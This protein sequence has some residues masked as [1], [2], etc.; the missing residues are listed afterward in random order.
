MDQLAEDR[1]AG[2]ATDRGAHGEEQRDSQGARLQWKDL[3]DGETGR[4][5]PAD[6]M[7][8]ASD[9]S[10]TNV[11]VVSRSVYTSTPR[12]ATTTAAPEYVPV[13]I[14]RRPT[15]SRSNVTA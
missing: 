4:A 15:V 14:G 7:K 8:N 5:R 9:T 12:S 2:D 3:T 11:P 1:G 6:A 13:I 10:R